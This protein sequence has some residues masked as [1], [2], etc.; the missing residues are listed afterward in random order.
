VT[1][2]TPEGVK[3]DIFVAAY[4]RYRRA[5]YGER[6]PDKDTIEFAKWRSGLYTLCG[7]AHL[8]QVDGGTT[9]RSRWL[10]A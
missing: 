1:V 9:E 8:A 10:K 4:D 6:M 3:D 7:R 5:L 2:K